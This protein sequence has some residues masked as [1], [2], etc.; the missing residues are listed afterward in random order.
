[1]GTTQ[2]ERKM[3]ADTMRHTASS[4]AAEQG[5]LKERVTG[6]ESDMR[7]MSK[8]VAELSGTVKD[9]FAEMREAMTTQA[10][11][12]AELMSA[13]ARRQDERTSEIHKRL[14][15]NVQAKQWSPTL[16]IAAITCS[17]LIAG[18]FVA[19]VQ[20]TTMPIAKD[21]SETRSSIEA[22]ANLA[23]HFEAMQDHA[24][25]EERFK[26]TNATIE[27][28]QSS[29]A[30]LDSTLQREMRLL[31]DTQTAHLN[32]L[33]ERLQREMKM[34]SEIAHGEHQAMAAIM[35]DNSEEIKK[36]YSIT[37]EVLMTR[38]KEAEERGYLTAQVDAIRVQQDRRWPQFITNAEARGEI[39]QMIAQLREAYK[40]AGV[41]DAA[42]TE[43]LQKLEEFVRDN[44]CTPEPK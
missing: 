43:R 42:I 10:T 7:N 44:T 39:T 15:E 38:A 12:Q 1:M 4:V 5:Q 2:G 29:I 34:M 24:T 25:Y 20:M 3:A 13:A 16:L 6:L 27:T 32:S 35:A 22:H 18:T 19:F 41:S 37:D 11:K 30:L 14:D 40:A 26:T 9:G 33:D 8:V 21:I 28:L 36:L 23:G 31:D 17:M